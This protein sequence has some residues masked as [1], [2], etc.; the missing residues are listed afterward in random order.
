MPLSHNIEPT[1]HNT[2]EQL[3][4]PSYAEKADQLVALAN[5]A[6]PESQLDLM[7]QF[8]GDVY[9][10]AETGDITNGREGEDHVVYTPDILDAQLKEMV[11]TLNTPDDETNPLMRVPRADGLRPAF[12]KLLTSES[13]ATA[14]MK[15]L[16]EKLRP[17][18]DSN[19][20]AINGSEKNEIVTVAE[21]QKIG[22]TA[23]E[24]SG[25]IIGVPDFVRNRYAAETPAIPNLEQIM[26]NQPIPEAGVVIPDLAAKMSGEAAPTAPETALTPEQELIALTEDLSD[27]DRMELRSYASSHESMIAARKDGEGENAQYYEQQKGQA[28][29]A[30][31][32]AAQAI[33]GKYLGLWLS[34]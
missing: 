33:K 34:I 23:L 18:G 31:S 14:L 15:A 30:M 19:S 3:T 1:A 21:A 9:T 29:H 11:K 6:D 17:L 12:D 22:G 32:P 16:E 8:V 28:Q 10:R 20:E 4:P 27:D 5:E 24:S 7:R 25:L 2:G 13:T 26:T